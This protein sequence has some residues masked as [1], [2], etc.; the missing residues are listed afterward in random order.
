M[1]TEMNYEDMTQRFI[2]WMTSD[3]AVNFSISI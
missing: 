1:P 2:R 3:D